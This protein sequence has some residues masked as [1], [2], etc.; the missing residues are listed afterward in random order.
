M[1]TFSVCLPTY[2]GATYL[3]SC[4][5]SLRTQ[6]YRDFELIICDD[7]ST[8]GTLEI[9]KRFARQAFCPPENESMHVLIG[10]YQLLEDRL[11][12]ED[13]PKMVEA[14]EIGLSHIEAR[15]LEIS[16]PTQARKDESS[17]IKT[18]SNP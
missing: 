4:L 8:D 14:I 18:F 2:N 13:A 9:L 3:N 15:S 5:E 10:I 11:G 16:C 1:T 6:T 12:R 7:G 17:S